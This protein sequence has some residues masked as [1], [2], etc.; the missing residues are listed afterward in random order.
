M[1]V[2]EMTL[3]N[4]IEHL[5]CLMGLLDTVLSNSSGCVGYCRSQ[6]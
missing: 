6:R 2:I 5:Q 4:L 1:R 3:S